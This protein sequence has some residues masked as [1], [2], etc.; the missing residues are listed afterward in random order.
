MQ[1]LFNADRESLLAE[2]GDLHNQIRDNEEALERERHQSLEAKNRNEM[3]HLRKLKQ[4]EHQC[5]S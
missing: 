2:I 1:Q 5:K 3:E 4:L